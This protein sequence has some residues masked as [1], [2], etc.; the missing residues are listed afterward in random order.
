M[1]VQTSSNRNAS[2]E[3]ATRILFAFDEA[4]PELG[5]ME[6]S[7]RVGLNKSTVSRFVASLTDLGLLERAESGRKV[8]LSLR[9]YEIGMVALR[10]RPILELVGATLTQTAARLGETAAVGVLIGGEIVFLERAG[11]G[12]ESVRLELGRRYPASRSAAG[13]VLLAG[14]PQNG[15][16]TSV[17]DLRRPERPL[18]FADE[19]SAVREIGYSTEIGEMIEG[20]N[21]VA[22]PIIDRSGQPIAALSVL[23]NG[24][25]GGNSLGPKLIQTVTLA[26]A[27]VSRKLGYHRA[28]NSAL[29]GEPTLRAEAG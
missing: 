24:A 16:A 9:L 20:V 5:V 13:R 11:G 26:A 18:R 12:R 23:T 22:A 27:E 14:G 6:L 2:L 21:A 29:P 25:R 28:P 17:R 4:T 10:H 8:R 7:R 1:K 15:S 3:K 19:L